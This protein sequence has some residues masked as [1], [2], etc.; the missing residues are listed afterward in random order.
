MEGS[1]IMNRV[2]W[3]HITSDDICLSLHLDTDR[4]INETKH[5]ISHPQK[6]VPDIAACRVSSPWSNNQCIVLFHNN[7]TPKGCQCNL[8]L[9][10]DMV[11]LFPKHPPRYHK[12]HNSY[13]SFFAGNVKAKVCQWMQTLGPDFSIGMRRVVHSGQMFLPLWWLYGKIRVV[14]LVLVGFFKYLSLSNKYE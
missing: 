3:S 11:I 2:V 4:S 13:S 8:G 14:P 10:K 1:I 7:G 12:P 6:R 9:L 5:T